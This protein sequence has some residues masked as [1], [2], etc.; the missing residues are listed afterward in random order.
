MKIENLK[1]GMVIKNYKE[2]CELLEIKPTTGRGKQN[3]LLLLNT[4]C[5]YHKQGNK[6]IIDNIFKE[7]KP[8]IKNNTFRNY[9]RISNFCIDETIMN[10][11][12]IYYIIEN[13]NIYIGST[14][15]GFRSRFRDHYNKNN[16][17]KDTYMMLHN[18]GEFHLFS[19]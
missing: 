8:I 4:W 13:N 2:L 16:K 6:F 14:T 18:Q 19:V 7:Q 3:Q 5:D 17:N 9:H 15:V 12:G 11:I 10:N 1:E